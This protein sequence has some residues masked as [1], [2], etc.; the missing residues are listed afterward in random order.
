MARR[1]RSLSRSWI[2]PSVDSRPTSTVA[3]R[4]AI[5]TS[6]SA[7]ISLPQ[8]IAARTERM[9]TGAAAAAEG[10]AGELAAMGVTKTC[11]ERRQSQG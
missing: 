11:F 1:S 8:R 10:R 5:L 3:P 6:R 2:M 7:K 9:V 4:S